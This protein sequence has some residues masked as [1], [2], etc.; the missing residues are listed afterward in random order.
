MEF[1]NLINR[2]YQ[3]LRCQLQNWELYQ[4]L[5][6]LKIITQNLLGAAPHFLSFSADWVI[7]LNESIRMLKT[8][9]F[10]RQIRCNCQLLLISSLFQGLS[11]VAWYSACVWQLSTA[12]KTIWC[13]GPSVKCGPNWRTRLYLCKIKV[14]Q[15]ARLIQ[16]AQ[17]SPVRAFIR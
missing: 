3:F 10:F 14:M 1:K 8:W 16:I 5:N 2:I 15:I 13:N 4:F 9:W 6:F 7:H 17:V 12:S 11:L